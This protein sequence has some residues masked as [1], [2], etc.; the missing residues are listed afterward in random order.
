MEKGERNRRMKRCATEELNLKEVMDEYSWL[1]FTDLQQSSNLPEEYLFLSIIVALSHWTNGAM[2]EGVNI[3]K[4]PIILFGILC[5]GSGERI[6][7]NIW[8]DCID[9]SFRSTY[10]KRERERFQWISIL[11]GSKKSGPIRLIKE[12]SEQVESLNGVPITESSLNSSATME[13]IC[14][15]L[16]TKP[17]LLQA[18]L[19]LNSF[20]LVHTFV[21]VGWTSGVFGFIR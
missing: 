4:I 3:Y 5:G 15:E 21:G 9:G 8:N 7:S 20:G 16:Q 13:S 11:L 12:A 2:I 19:F 18:K 1:M 6:Y 10:V 17:H 14:F